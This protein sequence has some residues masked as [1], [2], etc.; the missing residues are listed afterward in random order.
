MNTFCQSDTHKN[1]LCANST[2]IGRKILK[3]FSFIFLPMP[4]TMHFTHPPPRDKKQPLGLCWTMALFVTALKTRAPG[5]T[6][7]DGR[8]T[9]LPQITP[10]TYSIRYDQ[11][12]LLFP[13]TFY[14]FRIS[15][16]EYP[17]PSPSAHSSHEDHG[18]T[19][20]KPPSE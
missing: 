9:L 5:R 18:F 19:E 14:T 13:G 16:K 7:S 20:R 4:S 8:S 12:F 15:H 2:G 17:H 6:L 11:Q 10:F 3:S 1:F